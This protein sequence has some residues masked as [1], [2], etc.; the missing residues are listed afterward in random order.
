MTLILTACKTE[1]IHNNHCYY[2]STFIIFKKYTIFMFKLGKKNIQD[3]L[4]ENK[5]YM[6]QPVKKRKILNSKLRLS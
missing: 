5:I 3:S 1:L 2:S 6:L 4:Q